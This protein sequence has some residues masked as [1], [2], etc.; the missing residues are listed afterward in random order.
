MAKIWLKSDE[1]KSTFTEPVREPC[2]VRVGTEKDAEHGLGAGPS[3]GRRSRVR[4]LKRVEAEGSLC[5][6]RWYRVIFVALEFLR[7]DFSF[8]RSL[9]MCEKCKGN[10]YITT[11][12]YYPS[13]NLHIGHAYCTVATDAMAQIGRAHV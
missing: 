3:I 8:E 6:T 1:K 2:Q 9:F 12:I 10:Y 4:P 13:A 5:E 11:P 7:G